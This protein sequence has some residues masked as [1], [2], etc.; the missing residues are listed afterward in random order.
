MTEKVYRFVVKKCHKGVYNKY[1]KSKYVKG[2]HPVS[3]NT[4]KDGTGTYET[5]NKEI[6]DDLSAKGFILS[7]KEHE[8]SVATK[9]SNNEAS[10]PNMQYSNLFHVNENDRIIFHRT[11]IAKFLTKKYHARIVPEKRYMFLYNYF[12]NIYELDYGSRFRT[13]LAGMFGDFM[14]I[15]ETN[16]IMEK[17]WNY[18]D[19][20]VRESDLSWSND[21]FMNFTNGVLNLDTMELEK[22]NPVK[23][24]FQSVIPRKYD[25]DAKCPE[26]LE[27]L[28]RI[29]GKEE[30]ENQLEWIGFCL[31]PGYR[32]KMIMFY[33]G[34]SDGGKST[35]FNLLTDL[36]H[37]DNVVNI[38]PQDMSGNYNTARL[39]GKMINIA[40]D[41]GKGRVKNFNILRELSGGDR[42][43]IREI[44]QAPV[45]FVNFAK[46][47]FGCNEI[48][49]FDDVEASYNRVKFVDCTHVFTDEEKAV[50][51][52]KI[53]RTEEELSGLVN[54]GLRAYKNTLKRGGFVREDAEDTAIIH[55][56]K[57]YAIHNWARDK[58]EWGNKDDKMFMIELESSYKN[59]CRNNNTRVEFTGRS[60][61]RK[62][63][64]EFQDIHYVD[65]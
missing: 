17:I 49:D 14:N 26:T 30:L 48:P 61:T 21:H 20:Q 35:Y 13:E 56:N 47:M 22:H 58:L 1:L 51:D 3:G 63:R 15:K 37:H 19:R 2:D 43:T 46:L 18:K 5:C 7:V 12:H 9:L 62:F 23:Y 44:R 11:D 45:E 27:M 34:P 64:L 4:A 28:E 60:F 40:A 31:T 36:V 54:E 59:W 41:I 8:K 57:I 52:P 10:S 6:V 32:F 65:E 25:P 55:H 50:F 38:S 39:Q 53:Y 29:F 33:N 42:T 16:E 24:F